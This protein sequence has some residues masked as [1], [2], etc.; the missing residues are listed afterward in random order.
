MLQKPQLLT[1]P[2]TETSPQTQPKKQPHNTSRITK[3]GIV[4]FLVSC[5]LL[6]VNSVPAQAEPIDTEPTQ[7]QSVKIIPQELQVNADSTMPTVSRDAVTAT[8]MDALNAERAA[9]AAAAAAAKAAADEAARQVQ[10]AAQ[11]ATAHALQAGKK[12]LPVAVAPGQVIPAS[13]IIAA[14]QQWVGVVPYGNGN[15]PSDSFACDG[16]V[17]Y[18]F[19]QNGISLPRGVTAQA[20]RG[21]VI[22]KADAKAGDLVV[23]PGE[24]IGIYDGNGGMYNSPDWGRYVEHRTSLWG[25]PIFVRL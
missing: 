20:S 19:A 2:K 7:T 16:Y 13:G 4:S 18:V 11:Q 15:N 1:V 6:T 24:H 21:T 8:S 10:I 3:V 22:S 9:Q 14:A 5:A 17:Q 25:D 12:P 23:W